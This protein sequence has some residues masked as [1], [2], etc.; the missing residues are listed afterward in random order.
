MQRWVRL[1]AI[2]VGALLLSGRG[3]AQQ[4]VGD[5]A[6]DSSTIGADG[7]AYVTRVIPVPK[8]V[9]PEA[10]AMLGRVVS[11][12]DVPQ[13]LQQRREGTDRWQN[14]AGEASKKLYPAHVEEAN[15]AGV[16]VRVVTP[17]A[18]A[19]EKRDRVLINLHGGGFNSDSGSLTET[20]PIASLSG[21]GCG[22]LSLGA[23]ASV[24]C[25]V[26]RCGRGL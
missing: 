17:L 26:G 24:P 12:A 5:S 1:I 13:T 23:G 16:P 22:A 21:G 8:T 7:T 6:R 19:S 3:V 25:G 18:I 11:D 20:I 2:L 4:A 10:Q 15:I 9:S 14:G